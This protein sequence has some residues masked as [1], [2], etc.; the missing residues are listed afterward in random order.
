MG[1]SF[2]LICF[3]TEIKQQ[4]KKQ[5]TLAR[6]LKKILDVSIVYI[7]V[8]WL[9]DLKNNQQFLFSKN[10]RIKEL[11]VSV[12]WE[13]IKIREPHLLVV[14]ETS[15]NRWLERSFFE[16]IFFFQNQGSKPKPNF[17]KIKSPLLGKWVNTQVNN[18]WVL[19]LW[20]F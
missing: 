8:V 14:S 18:W 2:L 7:S 19:V 16:L 1:F 12:F 11:L 17:Q 6:N 10:F 13:N 9:F 3:H 20:K 4:L 5:P 15:K